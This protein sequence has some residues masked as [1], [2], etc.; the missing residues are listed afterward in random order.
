VTLPGDAGYFGMVPLTGHQPAKTRL[1]GSDIEF[2]GI[3]L[4]QE[5]LPKKSEFA[6]QGDK[7][8]FSA[9]WQS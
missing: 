4:R 7:M 9:S 2:A 8:S 6:L 5:L 3:S 1:S